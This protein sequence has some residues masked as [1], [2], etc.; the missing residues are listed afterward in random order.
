MCCCSEPTKAVG[1]MKDPVCGM[2]VDPAKAAA[3]VEHKGTRYFFCSQGCVTKFRADPQKYLAPE[4]PVAPL[5][6]QLHAEQQTEYI[7]PMD[8]EVHRMGPGACPKC[9]MALELAIITA[10]ATRTDFTCPMHPQIS[11]QEPGN[12]PICGMTLE[13]R[14]STADEVTPELV[15]MTRRFWI[16]VALA[17][18]LL[19]LMVSDLIPSM[20]LQHMLSAR[21]WAWTEFALAALSH[22][23]PTLSS[24]Q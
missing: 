8:P 17:V 15:D 10:L 24:T 11:R 2:K 9:G 12:C 14:E 4:P 6:P 23:S 22:V 18:P 20:P 16:S 5:T 3:A 7:C 13:S 1:N 21:T 19:A